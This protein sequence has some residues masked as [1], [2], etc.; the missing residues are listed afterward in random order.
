MITSFI[1]YEVSERIATITLNRPEAANA[2]T[3]AL[4]DD[5]DEAWRRAADDPEV[6]VIILRA[7]GKHF[8]AGHDIKGVGP[9]AASNGNGAGPKWTLG[10]IYETEAKRFLEY[11]LRWRNIPKPSIAAVQGVCI[12]GGLLLAWP[13]D[14]IVAADNAKFS[15]PVVMMGIGG[16]EY[17]G[18]TWEMGP[19]KAKEI[20]FTG[21]AMTAEEAAQVG[22]VNRVV[23]LDELRPAVRELATQIA[24]MHPFALRQAKRAVNQT[25]DVQGFYAAIQSVFDIHQTGHGHALSESGLPILTLLDDMKTAIKK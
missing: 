15:D 11:T 18:H 3:S 17:H 7:N 24:Q 20:L 2:Q 14:L 12:S 13:C 6:R 22:M 16:V 4:L 23:P 19:R 9:R 8:S 21:R 25:L 5:L 10:G 1:G